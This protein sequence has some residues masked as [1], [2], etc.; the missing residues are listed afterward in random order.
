MNTT[1]QN[2]SSQIVDD[3]ELL[4]L[5]IQDTNNLEGIYQPGPYWANKTK[6]AVNEIN[7][8][9][10]RDFR[11]MKNGAATSY[12]DNVY[13]DTRGN[14]NFGIRALFLKICRQL[15]RDI[16]PFNRL[17]D[18][19]VNL[20]FNYFQEAIGYKNFYLKNNERVK[21]LL[22]KYNLNFETTKGGCLS[23][24]EFNGINISHHYLQLLDT[25]DNIDDKSSILNKKTFLEIGGGFGVNA[26]LIIELF[27]VKKIIYLD[28]VPN[29]YVGTQY[30][31]SFYG[32]K[33]I[34][35]KKSKNMEI[36]KF[37]DTDEL[38]I[39][40]ITPQQ[41]EKIKSQIDLFHNAHSFVEMPENIIDNYAKKVEAI[42]S[43]DNSTISLV[44][45]DGYDLN[46]TINPDK[47]PD[48]FTKTATK[49]I[50][51]TLTP[52]RSNFYFIIE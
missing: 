11:G 9:G 33:I 10:L 20:T 8:F 13:V 25:L 15:N 14:Y 17:F 16:Y 32:E 43:K 27:K 52:L 44:S 6:S 38:E 12:G 39:F 21:Y 22:S 48:F 47:L 19:Q 37:S 50:I 40:C 7:K 5:M 26:H 34:D 1:V 24:G 29:L 3:Y 28:I 51:P 31:K 42:L 23:F 46:T 35:Y 49:F 2:N 4:N 18:S 30:L 36:I 45:Y 41:I